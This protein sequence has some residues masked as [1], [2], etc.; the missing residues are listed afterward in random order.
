LIVKSNGQWNYI[1]ECIDLESTNKEKME[2]FKHF[3]KKV[4]KKSN[5]WFQIPNI[6]SVYSQN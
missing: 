6:Q 2:M 5:V 1:D 3:G 4:P